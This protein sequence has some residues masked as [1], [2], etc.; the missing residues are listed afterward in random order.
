MMASGRRDVKRPGRKFA[1][2]PPGLRHQLEAEEDSA[3]FQLS[4]NS[5]HRGTE[6]TEKIKKGNELWNKRNNKA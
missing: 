6:S 4:P 3:P 5:H 2:E 1:A